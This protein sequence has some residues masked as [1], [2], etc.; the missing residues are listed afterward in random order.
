MVQAVMTWIARDIAPCL[1]GFLWLVAGTGALPAEAQQS[2]FT[3]AASCGASNCH[4]S[5]KPKADFPKLDE[6]LQWAKKDKHA[7]AY[8]TLMNEKLKSGVSPA[9][10][11]KALTLAKAET[12]ERCLACHAVNAPASLRGPKF[13]ITEGVHCDGCHGPAEKWLEPHAEK[14]W[15]HEKSVQLGMYD[16]KSLL[17]RAEKCV[18]CHLQIE[19][20]M[21]TAGHPETLT[22]ELDTFSEN[23]PPH[24]GTKGTW[25]RTRIWGLGQVISLRES[26]KQLGARAKAN[27]AGPLMEE[28]IAKVRGHFAMAKHVLA[29]TAPPL[30]TSLGQD[31]TALNDAVTKGDKAAA[32]TLAAKIST[33]AGQEAPKIATREFDQA[34]TQRIIKS[35]AG[36]ADAI[37]AA[38][39]KAAELAAM[40]LDRLS[41][42]Y[43]KGINAKADKAV[44]DALDGMFGAVENPAKYDAKAFVT[45]VKAFDKSFK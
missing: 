34:T 39:I 37:G 44:N 15:T 27:A 3:G 45:Q 24:W 7:Q 30:A 12:S 21:V 42:T 19:A 9:K 11:A 31:V 6:N 23:M 14:G 16:T 2:K 40:T 35:V 25:T 4:G 28:A 1:V 10:I 29:V 43:F 33:A 41:S 5:T 26:A 13:D 36:D 32:Q 8:A 17:L 18:A 38:G 20:D 22:I